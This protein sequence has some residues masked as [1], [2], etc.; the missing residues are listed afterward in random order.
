MI[1]NGINSGNEDYD[2]TIHLFSGS[3]DPKFVAR[4]KEKLIPSLLVSLVLSLHG[5]VSGYALGYTAPVE[6]SIVHSETNPDGI[7]TMPIFTIFSSFFNIGAAVGALSTVFLSDLIGRKDTLII[8][9]GTWSLGFLMLGVYPNQW[10][11]IAGRIITGVALGM[12]TSVAPMYMGEIATA[13]YRGMLGTLFQLMI[14]IGIL[15]AYVVGTPFAKVSYGYLW[16]GQVGLGISLVSLVL[17]VFQHR[18]PVWLVYKGREEEAM[19]ALRVLRGKTASI[20]NDMSNAANLA[21]SKT[22]KYDYSI[23]FTKP[24]FMPFLL[25]AM[26]MA[27]QQLSGINAVI[28]YS[29]DILKEAVP[30]VQP[31]LIPLPPALVQVIVTF[32]ASFFV[33]RLGRKIM[34]LIASFGMCASSITIGTYFILVDKVYTNCTSVHTN[35][36]IACHVL[37]PIVVIA[38]CCFLGFFSVA[39]GPIPWVFASEILNVKL[40]NV[41]IAIVTLCSWMSSFVVTMGFPPFVNLVHEYGGF[42]TFAAINIIGII[43][44]LFF[45]KETKG[46]TLEQLQNL[47][48]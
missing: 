45:L 47:Y 10:L 31:E 35:N 16:V 17:L 24:I 23:I 30:E 9:L 36:D 3:L 27:F 20:Q 26:L 15:L 5:L 39:W 43:F 1:T 12:S 25:S 38:V 13:K 4:R 46:K 33:D 7:M 18:S 6:T 44:I 42:Y 34:L 29:T 19:L 2:E 14:T 21:A 40:K 22:E 28:F 37:S 48:S 11:L 41:T 32:A 8:S